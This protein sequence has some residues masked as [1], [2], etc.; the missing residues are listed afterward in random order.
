MFSI[1]GQ[2]GPTGKY[3]SSN[4]MS[5]ISLDKNKRDKARLFMEASS[6]H[7]DYDADH[8]VLLRCS[9]PLVIDTF[10]GLELIF[11]VVLKRFPMKSSCTTD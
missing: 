9:L 3:A 2:L 4:W 1:S 11:F 6:N 8:S 10:I 5:L 7:S